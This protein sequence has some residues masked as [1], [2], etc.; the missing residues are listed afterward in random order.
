VLDRMR[1]DDD[2][3]ELAA[4]SSMSALLNGSRCWRDWASPDFLKKRPDM[5]PC[6]VDRTGHATVV[7]GR[8]EW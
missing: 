1:S 6:V 4:S 7:Q 2:G 3:S 8:K 5:I